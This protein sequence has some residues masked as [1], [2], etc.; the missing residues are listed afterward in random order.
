MGH[1]PIPG[2]ILS[3]MVATIFYSSQA[4]STFVIVAEGIWR[5][6]EHE[7]FLRLLQEIELSLKL[8]LNQDVNLDWCDRK[9]RF[10]LNYLLW[11]SLICYYLV[12]YY[13]PTLEY[14]AYF[15]SILWFV[16]TM[17]FRL[18]QLL[19]YVRVLQHYME[20]LC[21]K[22]RQIVELRVAPSRQLMDVNYEKLQSLEYLQAIKEIYA[23]LFREFQ[24]LNDFAG[25]SLF[26]LIT[27][28]AFDFGFTAY[29][30]IITFE[31]CVKHRKHYFTLLW[32]VLTTSVVVCH[33]CLLCDKC[34]KLEHTLAAL[35][36]KIIISSSSKSL[37]QYRLL[38]HQFSTQLQL[39]P[40]EVTAK[41]FFT[42]DL[43]LITWLTL[44]TI[45]YLVILI[46]FLSL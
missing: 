5:Q 9:V 14:N 19:L 10:L 3:W 42:L 20:C 23:L 33:I 16:F 1:R 12:F 32:W 35:M 38:V 43:R 6:Q 26:G 44:S 13:S 11:M 34:K 28:Y 46:E 40:I 30:I 31:G 22:V 37:R 21:M 7:E 39:Q 29:C 17:R 18:I 27:N 25:W 24:L 8:R 45:T 15:W 36:S 41:H 4:F 2:N